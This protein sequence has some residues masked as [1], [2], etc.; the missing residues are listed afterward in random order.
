MRKMILGKRQVARGGRSI[1][2]GTWTVA[3]ALL[4]MLLTAA[5]GT[6]RQTPAN[7]APETAGAVEDT[8]ETAGETADT[9]E[10]TGETAGETAGA[11]PLSLW[12]EEAA[13]KQELTAFIHLI[14]VKTEQVITQF[15]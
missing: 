10:E 6:T 15:I 2:C 7:A 1:W 13:A 3:L 8:V 14:S 4:L 5:C 12:T 9:L 11:D